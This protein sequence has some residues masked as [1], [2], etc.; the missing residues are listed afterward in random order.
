MD[1][2]YW[3]SA[4]IS[5]ETSLRRRASRDLLLGTDTQKLSGVVALGSPGKKSCFMLPAFSSNHW[6]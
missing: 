4:I 6:L 5:K 1:E 2:R 3:L